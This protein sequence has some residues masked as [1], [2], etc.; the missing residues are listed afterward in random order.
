MH[1]TI[2]S[3]IHLPGEFSEAR[4]DTAALE[5]DYL[6]VE[7]PEGAEYDFDYIGDEP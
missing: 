7:N 5:M 2:F 3:F 1:Y 4:E 6:E